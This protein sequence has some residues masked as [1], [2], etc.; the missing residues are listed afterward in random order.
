MLHV[1]HSLLYLSIMFQQSMFQ[2]CNKYENYRRTK[3]NMAP[4]LPK[5]YVKLRWRLQN[6]D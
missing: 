2:A 4:P 6:S 5:D 1:G 3:V